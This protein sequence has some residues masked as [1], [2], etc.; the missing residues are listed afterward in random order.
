MGTLCW[1]LPPVI[2]WISSIFMGGAQ[3]VGVFR[4]LLCDSGAQTE[5]RATGVK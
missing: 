4:K 5:S 1:P 3:E 2:Y